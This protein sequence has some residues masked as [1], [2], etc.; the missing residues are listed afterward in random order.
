MAVSKLQPAEM[1][2]AQ[3]LLYFFFSGERFAKMAARHSLFVNIKAPDLHARWLEG[4]WPKPA[5][6][7]QSIKF[8]RQQLSDLRAGFWQ[9][10]LWVIAILILAIAF[11]L[12]MGKSLPLS[13]DWKWLAMAG[14]ALAAWGTI[15]QLTHV[16]M[17]W[18]GESV[19][20]L[21]RPPLFLLLFVPGS[22]LALAGTLA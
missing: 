11:L 18:G 5:E 8:S 2:T 12:G 20:E 4:I 15:F 9:S 3:A 14:G 22:V 21:L 17:T 19:F 1:K 16:P 10:A 6:T 7:E 13:T